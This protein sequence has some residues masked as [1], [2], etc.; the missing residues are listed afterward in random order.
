MLNNKD[1]LSDRKSSKRKKKKGSKLSVSSTDVTYIDN[2]SRETTINAFPSRSDIMNE[3]HLMIESRYLFSLS[4]FEDDNSPSNA[5]GDETDVATAILNLGRKML[6]KDTIRHRISPSLLLRRICQQC[7]IIIQAR[8]YDFASKMIFQIND[9]ISLV[10]KTKTCEPET[11]LPEFI[12]CLTTSSALLQ[13]GNGATAF[14]AAQQAWTII[15]QVC[16]LLL[17][18]IF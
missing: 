6:A 5:F 1:L 2:S 12:D 18:K 13:Q 8:D 14:E 16:Y 11:Y 3:L 7:G 9:I 10:P 17:P 4:L 15:N